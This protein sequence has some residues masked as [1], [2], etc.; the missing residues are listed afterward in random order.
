MKTTYKKIVS[1][2][3]SKARR[4]KKDVRVFIREWCELFEESRVVGWDRDAFL[5]CCVDE[6]KKWKRKKK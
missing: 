4:E 6:S 5:E 2:I 1:A 3:Y